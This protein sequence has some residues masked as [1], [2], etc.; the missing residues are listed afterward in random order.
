M[1]LWPYIFLLNFY[2]YSKPLHG[3]IVTTCVQTIYYHV[4]ECDSKRDSDW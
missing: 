2:N 1:Y 4:T 3:A